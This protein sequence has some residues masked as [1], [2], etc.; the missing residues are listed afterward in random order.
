MTGTP[1]VSGAVMLDQIR[2]M[3]ELAGPDAV[4]AARDSLPPEQ[5]S[6]LEHVTPVSWLDSN[7]TAE[8][9]VRVAEH[10]GKDPERFQID[11]VRLGVERTLNTLWRVI[12]KFT[13]DA[14]LV[15]RTP[16]LYSKTYDV[17]QLTSRIMQ[18]GRADLE[19]T[20]WPGVPRMELVG[21]ATGIETVLRC[22][23]RQDVRVTFDRRPDGAVFIANWRV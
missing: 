21:L 23:G 3:E 22:A 17:G 2:V 15:K 19:L 8:F 18:P 1:R 9:V 13:T 5:R 6:E 12:L 14:A 10:I 11:V 20:G 4:R 16:L 7:A